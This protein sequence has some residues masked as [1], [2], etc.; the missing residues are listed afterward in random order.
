MKTKIY[1]LTLS[2]KKFSRGVIDWANGRKVKN[3]KV[4]QALVRGK[5]RA[6]R[7]SRPKKTRCNYEN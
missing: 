2:V 5:K 4:Q 6:Y 1:Y 3:S 7:L